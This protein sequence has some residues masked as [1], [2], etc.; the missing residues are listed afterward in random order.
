MTHHDALIDLQDRVA[1]LEFS[2]FKEEWRKITSTTRK[3]A[4]AKG[5]GEWNLRTSR[6]PNG[7]KQF[8]MQS[9]SGGE[10]TTLPADRKLWPADVRLVFE[11]FEAADKANSR[12]GRRYSGP[13]GSCEIR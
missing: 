8:R 2:K 4:P 11:K 10:W 7:K 1:D 9:A 3:T 6:L 5:G 12:G 13:G